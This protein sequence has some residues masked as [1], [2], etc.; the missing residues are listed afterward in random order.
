MPLSLKKFEIFINNKGILINNVYCINKEVVYIELFDINTAESFLV[1][2]PSKYVMK[3]DER[4][5]TF[6]LKYLE[7]N[8][9]EEDFLKREKEKIE[10]EKDY[11]DID[12]PHDKND[13]DNLEDIL[14]NNYNRPVFLDD[15]NV[16]DKDNI[17]DLYYQLLRLKLC[18]QNIKYKICISYKNYLCCIKRD[19]EIESY[20]IKHF[21]KNKERK[22]YICIDLENFYS[23][24]SY[25]SKDLYSVKK[26]IYKIINQNQEKNIRVLNMIL[27]QKNTLTTNFEIIKNK[28]LE[29]DNYLNTLEEL[30]KKINES[31][32]QVIDKILKI[33]IKFEN[34]LNKDLNNDIQRSHEL[35]VE[36]KKMEEILKV[37][38]ELIKDICKLKIKKQNIL[39]LIDKILFD[40]S[41][42]LNTVNNNFINL[43]KLI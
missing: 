4:K 38:D 27:E 6:K 16:E 35:S 42:M 14:K 21:P 11:D 25:L 29:I 18:V 26:G 1:Y 36:N 37:K 39:L 3:T 24:I 43:T 22:I 5:N 19:N 34:S 10:L 20:C 9:S 17:K 7:I 41:I 31:E 15:L 23:K 28:K 30:F 8:E 40:N 32:K 12:L 13:S 33:N 2:I